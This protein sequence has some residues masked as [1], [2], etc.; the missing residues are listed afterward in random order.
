MTTVEEL[1][2]FEREVAQMFLNKELR[3]PVHLEASVDG[4]LELFLIGL[5][6]RIWKQDWC[7]VTYRN[8]IYAL[9]KGVPREELKQWIKDNKSIHFMSKEHRIISSAIVGGHLPEAVGVAMGIKL[10]G[11]DEHVYAFCGDM[12]AATGIFHECAKYARRNNLPITFVVT[13]NGLSTDTITQDA[14]GRE[15]GGPNV[16]RVSY[17]RVYCHYG[18]WEE[19][20]REFVR[21]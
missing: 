16:L 5:F 1:Q 13:D 19:G 12:C 20:K 17:K 15:D 8:H 11:E 21:F 7:A 2:G 6:K 10:R 14:W 9:L 3:S 4:S 18:P